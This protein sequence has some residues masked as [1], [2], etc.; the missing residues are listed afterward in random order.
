VGPAQASSTAD[1][2]HTCATGQSACNV[3]STLEAGMR[4]KPRP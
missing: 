1:T 2:A 3:D 4:D